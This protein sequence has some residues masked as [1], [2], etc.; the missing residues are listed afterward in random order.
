MKPINSKTII[1]MV[2][3]IVAMVVVFAF[4]VGYG[5][6]HNGYDFKDDARYLEDCG[7]N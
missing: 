7:D 4:M 6:T 2:L 5:Y 3:I 1:I